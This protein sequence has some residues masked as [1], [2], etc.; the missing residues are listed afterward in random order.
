MSAQEVTRANFHDTLF[1]F[2]E[3]IWAEFEFFDVLSCY[4]AVF[5]CGKRLDQYHFHIVEI[6][7]KELC[8][9]LLVEVDQL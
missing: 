5:V 7:N 8:Q 1:D 2:W 4:L 6:S 9:I 3:V